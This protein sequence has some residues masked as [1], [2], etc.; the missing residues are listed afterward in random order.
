LA[1]RISNWTTKGLLSALIL[2]SGLA[3]GRQVIQW[4]STESSA[5]SVPQDAM[6]ADGLGDMEI[7]HRVDFGQTGWSM[8]RQSFNGSQDQAALA[9]RQWSERV[10]A[11]AQLPSRPQ[12]AAER[13]LLESLSGRR[14]V[15][16]SAGQWEMYE[17]HATL[18]MMA[19]I[20]ACSL[21]PEEESAAGVHPERVRLVTWSIAVPTGTTQ[22]SLYAFQSA[23][24]DKA[25]Q[26]GVT[27][28]LPPHSRTVLSLQADGGAA[29]ICFRGVGEADDWKAFYDDWYD[30]H[31]WWSPDDWHDRGGMHHRRYYDDSRTPSQSVDIQFGCF[32][33]RSLTGFLLVSPV[34]SQPME[35]LL[36]SA[37]PMNVGRPTGAR[38]HGHSRPN[39]RT[40]AASASTGSQPMEEDNP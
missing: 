31:A 10:T 7:A 29:T 20:R 40:F 36:R 26:K 9:L 39:C 16:A 22:W 11:S 4:W 1:G 17:Y 19:G 2:V 32:A 25:C 18:P 34:T 8:T 14:P 6:P 30:K 23:A 21:G 3:F 28:P 33:D 37:L 5:P 24:E 12:G 38:T 35:L 13:K 15:K 27:P